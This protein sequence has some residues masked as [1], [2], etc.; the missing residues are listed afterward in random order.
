MMNMNIHEK[1]MEKDSLYK[2]TACRTKNQNYR[3]T[4]EH[5]QPQ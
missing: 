4:Y 2:K 5:K 1:D 3:Q